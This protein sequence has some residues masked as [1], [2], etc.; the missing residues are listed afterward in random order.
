MK[1]YS[2]PKKSLVLI[3]VLI[4]LLITLSLVSNALQNGYDLFQKALAKERGEG[5]LEEAIS[6]YQKVV[7]EASDKSLAAKAQLRIGI[8]YEKLGWK[9]AQKA[10][11]KVID[12]YPGQTDTVKVAKEK[13]A[14]L[15]RAQTVVE[16]GDKGLKITQVWTGRDVDYMGAPSPDGKYISFVDWDTG[17]L[18]IRELA[19]GKKRRIT[20]K[21]SWFGSPEF[22]LNSRWSPDSKM[23]AYH[24]FNKDLFLDLRIIE[25]DSS[26]SRILYRNEEVNISG[27][28]DWSPDGKYILAGY[29]RK[30]D[31]TVDVVLIS[32]ED[33][34]VRVIKTFDKRYPAGGG[35]FS[36]D[37]RFI[38]YDFPQKENSLECDIFLLSIDGKREIPL[39]ENPANDYVLGWTPDGKSVLFA[40]DRTGNVDAWAIKV[41][42]GEPQ[43]AAVLI[44]RDIGHIWPMGFTREGS[45]YYGLQTGMRDV[46]FATL[47]PDKGKLTAPPTKAAQRFVGSNFSPYW[48]PDGKY[49]VYIREKSSSFG[50]FGASRVLC[51]LTL[52]TGEVRELSL[53]DYS[54]IAVPCWSPQGNSI[55]IRCK[56]KGGKT[57]FSIVDLKTGNVT[58]IMEIKGKEA[59]ILTKLCGW[60]PDGKEIIYWRRD[61]NTKTQSILAY[62]LETGQEREV[63]RTS[64]GR[65]DISND[66]D[67][68]AFSPDGK[69]LAF[70]EWG[71][72]DKGIRQF[73]KIMPA[74]G[75]ESREVMKL[76]KGEYYTTIEWTLDGREIIFFKGIS[77]K[78][79]KQDCE[80]WGVPVEGG[81][82]NNLGLTMDR[83]H[84]LRIHPD[85]RR[86]VF[87]SGHNAAEVWVMENF[88]PKNKTESKGEQK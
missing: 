2:I 40:S 49:L 54:Y 6:L 9:E 32:V 79:Q 56:D 88:L 76:R 24:W 86:I 14:V 81:D 80:M 18:A 17:D 82:P 52:E 25:L 53:M 20:N 21:G 28:G 51:I 31:L 7:K 60:T 66:T 77:T 65:G 10:F 85:G 13:L 59:G 75:G 5:N 70:F 26:K 73:L 47:D 35:F 67:E 11:Q 39:V 19:T 48:S 3:A 74:S 27:P 61:A 63:Y 16:K 43:G 12:N 33:G 50:R 22:A 38:V 64:M 83:V 36:A 41:A 37:G 72:V 8:C 4:S 68:L 78:I 42:E 34:S 57:Y 69:W 29:K 46:Y 58:P 87:S 30:K 55:I 44:K 62:N 1:K 84:D 23:I 15:L 45:F 71:E